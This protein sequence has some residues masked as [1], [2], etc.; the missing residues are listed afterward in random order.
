[1]AEK[2]ASIVRLMDTDLEGGKKAEFAITKIP[3][4]GLR[5]ARAVCVAAGIDPKVPIG[6]LSKEQLKKLEEVIKNPPAYGVPD[7]MLNRRRDP[8][9]GENRHVTGTELALTVRKDI[10]KLKKMK[11]WRGVRHALGLKVR[12]QRTRTTGRKGATVGVVK[13]KAARR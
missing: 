4:V 8:E 2:I 5:I 3:G 11:C 13:K 7:W 9:T 1:M 6:S 12:G 10:E